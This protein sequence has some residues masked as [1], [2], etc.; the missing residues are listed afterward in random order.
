VGDE[1]EEFI[2][3]PTP[4]Y[5]DNFAYYNMKVPATRAKILAD[6]SKK[7]KKAKPLSLWEPAM[8]KI[9]KSRFQVIETFSSDPIQEIE[10]WTE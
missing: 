4:G 3:K 9:H 1:E 6:S 8:K 10:L 5:M 2:I 7:S